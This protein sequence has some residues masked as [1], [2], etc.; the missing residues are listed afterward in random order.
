MFIDPVIVFDFT[1]L[2]PT[3]IIA[4]NLCYST[5]LGSIDEIIKSNGRK[6]FGVL[7][8]ANLSFDILKDEEQIRKNIYISPNNVAFVKKNV[9]IYV[10]K[11]NTLLHFIQIY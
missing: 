5:C 9:N 1:S 2:Y 8:S 6:R 10:Y 3:A 7:D 4:Y 11:L